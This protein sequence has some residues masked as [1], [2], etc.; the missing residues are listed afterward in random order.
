MLR[1]V[2]IS[3][4][5]SNLTKPGNVV[6][7]VSIDKAGKANLMP[8]GWQMRTSFNPPMFAVSIGKTR[9]T[10]RLIS[11]QKE[12]VVAYPGEGMENVIEFCG[13]CSGK[14]VDKFKE[15][16]IKTEKAKFV[17][18]PL[19][20]DARANFECKLIKSLETGDHT[21]FVGQVVAAYENKDK[22]KILLNMRD[23]SF[24]AL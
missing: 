8:A 16:E 10:H 20:Q 9:Y 2:D 14:N 4:G 3:Y 19:L 15:C 12:F 13:S 1:E 6:L 24:K 5:L 23:G 18:P 17:S 21:I 7:V 22:K 11:E